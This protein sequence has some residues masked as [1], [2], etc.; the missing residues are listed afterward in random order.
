MQR[1]LVGPLVR[2]GPPKGFADLE[3]LVGML[4]SIPNNSVEQIYSAY[5]ELYK[6]YSRTAVADNVKN[7]IQRFNNLF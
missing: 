5:I 1:P 2:V 3:D 7:A 6:S 4:V